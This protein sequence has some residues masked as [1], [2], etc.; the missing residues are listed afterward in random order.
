[1]NRSESGTG[2][3]RGILLSPRSDLGKRGQV[4]A[5]VGRGGRLAFI[6][7]PLREASVR[8]PLPQPRRPLSASGEAGPSPFL[9]RRPP[10]PLQRSPTKR[11]SRAQV[12]FLWRPFLTSRPEFKCPVPPQYS[13]LSLC[14]TQHN[15]RLCTSSF[16]IRF[17]HW[18]VTS[19]RA[20][21]HAEH[22]CCAL[23]HTQPGHG[24][25]GV[26]P[27]SVNNCLS[28]SAILSFPKE[29]SSFSVLPYIFFNK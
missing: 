26:S 11:A 17:P 1:M 27:C 3:G 4:T 8:P 6:L 15:L 12:R 22:T 19:K 20:E 28:N 13:L 25:F 18:M 21:A 9:H 7:R 10:S 14:R 29:Y 2:V 23:M 5:L 16:F 24:L